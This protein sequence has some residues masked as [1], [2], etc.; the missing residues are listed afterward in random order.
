MG[1]KQVSVA[2]F[3]AAS[4]CAADTGGQADLNAWR[5]PVDRAP[6]RHSPQLQRIAAAHAQDMARN[7]FFSHTSSNGAS[8]AGRAR[9]PST[10]I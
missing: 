4:A 2:F 10:A 3:L 9:P 8:L 5:S 7:G 6:V 1:L